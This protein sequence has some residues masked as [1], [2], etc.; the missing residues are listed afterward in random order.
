[1]RKIVVALGGNA[2]GHNPTDQIEKVQNAVKPIVELVEQ[3]NEV[4][5]AHG[6]GP[7]VGMINLAFETSNKVSSKNPDM[8]FPECG[9]MSQGYIGYHLQNALLTELK[10]KGLKQQVATI[11][12]QVEVDALDKAFE[13]PTKPIGQFYDLETA[14]KFTKEKGYTM[15]EDASRGY[16]RVV[17]SPKPVNIVELDIIKTLVKAGHLVITVGGGGIPVV[18]KGNEY[19]G[20]PAVIDKDFASAK[21]ADLLDVDMLVIL[22]A[23][24]KVKI[25]FNT[26]EEKDLDH[27]TIKEMDDLIAQGHFLKGSM[28]PKI[29]A[30][31]AF[32]NG[33]KYRTAIIASLEEA[34]EAL[35]GHTGTRITN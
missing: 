21:L 35:L 30:A 20:V 16:R 6:N 33:K 8:P 19:V 1:M 11:V 32:V 7:Q 28:L 23:V 24:N 5:L 13:H 29:E 4:I 27:I 9:A 25:N 3:G 34:K 17:A 15:V 31:K 2:L 14:E 12:T 26:P 22:T 10:N 18:K